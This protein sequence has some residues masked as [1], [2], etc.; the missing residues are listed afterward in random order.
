MIRAQAM[1]EE[2][3]QLRYPTKLCVPGWQAG[4]SVRVPAGIWRGGALPA[5]RGPR[6]TGDIGVERSGGGRGNDVGK[7]G[8]RSESNVAAVL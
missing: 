7:R 2:L 5:L 6:A 1:L 8:D 4:G 3:R